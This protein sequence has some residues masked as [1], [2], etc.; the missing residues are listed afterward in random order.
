MPTYRV[1]PSADDAGDGSLALPFRTTA[2]AL[3]RAREAGDAVVVMSGNYTERLWIEHGGVAGAPLIIRS[4]MHGAAR[5]RPP[6][7]TY[8]TVNIRADH[9]VLDGFDVVGGA[10]HAG[11]IEGAHHVAV[12]DT[13]AHHSGGAG[14]GASRSEFIAICGSVYANAATNPY[15][16]SGIAIYQPRNLTGDRTPPGFRT[17]VVNNISHDKGESA[18]ITSEPSDG[19]GVIIDD[20]RSTQ[21][22]EHP[23][24]PFPTLV[25]GNLVYRRSGKGV[26]VHWSDHVTVANNTAYRNNRDPLNPTSW[27]AELS[28]IQLSHNVWINNIA[29]ADPSATPDNVAIGAFDYGGYESEGVA[30][31][32]TVTFNG[33]TGDPS[34]GGDAAGLPRPGPDAR[35]RGADPR[36]LDPVAGDF[37]LAATSPAVDAAVAG[38]WLSST[39]L[40]GRARSEGFVDIGALERG[41]DDR[42]EPNAAP[43]ARADDGFVLRAGATVRIPAARLLANDTDPNGD[44]LVVATLG[45]AAEGV[46]DLDPTGAVQ[47][48]AALDYAGPARFVYT[49]RGGFGGEAWAPVSLSVVPEAASTGSTLFGAAPY[50]AMDEIAEARSYEPAVR[51][52]PQTD[53]EAVAL[54]YWRGPQDAS[55]VD[56]RKLTLWSGDGTKLAVARSVFSPGEAG[57]RAVNLTP[58]MALRTGEVY[59]ASYAAS[60]RYVVSQHFFDPAAPRAGGPVATAGP[61]PGVFSADGGGR[62][63]PGAFPTESWRGSNYWVDVVF[64][65]R[66][67]DPAASA[68]MTASQPEA[69]HSAAV[70]DG[71][72]A[73]ALPTWRTRTPWD[74]AAAL[75]PFEGEAMVMHP[76][77]T[78]AAFRSLPETLRCD[79]RRP[80]AEARVGTETSRSEAGSGIASPPAPAHS[81]TAIIQLQFYIDLSIINPFLVVLTTL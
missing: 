81:R 14:I 44:P 11:D 3:D 27:R 68:A 21:A 77:T 23:A 65:A 15:H 39:D 52:T 33:A 50:T 79:S 18:A 66:A 16:T 69:M 17:L 13:T 9:V 70:A 51:F 22:P 55:D 42:A 78:H 53:G 76:S 49:A 71:K 36:F 62:G 6:E 73:L 43:V 1:S 4:E 24:Y 56:I 31:L 63:G 35:L 58:P 74:A 19:N 34:T 46:A 25:A 57:W 12:L 61:V 38:S 26:A 37:R 47:F 28:N 41:P 64:R 59:V 29:V 54:R 60:G 45:Q 7:G 72:W 80:F 48:S 67:D 5:I 10:G 75:V 40:T 20:F 8:S 32:G 2:A 30:W